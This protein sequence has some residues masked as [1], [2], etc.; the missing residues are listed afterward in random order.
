MSSSKVEAPIDVSAATQKIYFQK[1]VLKPNGRMQ[2]LLPKL[3]KLYASVFADPPWNEFKV[4][5]RN[6]Y[7]SKIDGDRTKCAQC[8][9]DLRPAYPENEV[10]QEIFSAMEKT[11]CLTV[12]EDTK[13]ALLGA[14]WG[15]V[16]SSKELQKRYDS[17]E[18]KALVETTV[19]PYMQ[20]D[21]LFYLSEVFVETIARNK[22]FGTT[23]TKT[24]VDRA[25][26]LNLSSVLRTHSDSPMARIAREKVA[27]DLILARG[28]DTDYEGRILF[29][30]RWCGLTVAAE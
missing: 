8:N 21:R 18:M 11:G 3:A 2:A 29:A 26:Q 30:R 15:F 5:D 17:E 1:D 19:A 23:M 12:F 16:C 25:V 14:A 6:H 24:L 20:E 9:G 4:C 27:M 13:G 28:Q 10:I 7:T 22:G